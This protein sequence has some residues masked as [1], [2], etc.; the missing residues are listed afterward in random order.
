MKYSL[1]TS[2]TILLFATFALG[3]KKSEE[4]VS[5]EISD[6]VKVS[7]EAIHCRAPTKAQA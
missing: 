3:L 4:S 1:A 2:L 7:K 6:E 5:A